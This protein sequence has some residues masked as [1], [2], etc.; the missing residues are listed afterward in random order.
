MARPTKQGLDYFPFDVGFF[1]DNKVRILITRYQSEGLAV[2]LYILCDIYKEGYYKSVEDMDDYIYI[3]ADAVKTSPD[4]VQQIIAFLRKRAM[5][6]I[7]EKDELTVCDLDAVITSHGIQKRYAEAIKSRK[8]SISDI[9]RG[10]WLLSE[11]E[12]AEIN[13]FYKSTKN[14][15]F[16]ENNPSFSEKNPD[17]SEKNSIKESKVKEKEIYKEKAGVPSQAPETPQE[18]DEQISFPLIAE[19]RAVFD[20]QAK[21][22]HRQFVRPTLDE[23]RAYAIQ[24]GREDLAERFYEYFEIGEWKD[25]EGKP[26]KNWK[27]KFLTWETNGRKTGI[28]SG[29]EVGGAAKPK[30][31][32]WEWTVVGADRK[33]ERKETG[34]FKH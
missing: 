1:G 22:K 15:S 23:V 30:D 14:S 13:A 28:A 7:F 26:V 4:K 25:S 32:R 33:D 18:C 21:A 34:V 3:I 19:E 8:K 2:Y 6:R 24:R 12:E 27:Q 17:K 29:G 10:Y 31:P 9:N 16:S 20:E 11:N 5:V